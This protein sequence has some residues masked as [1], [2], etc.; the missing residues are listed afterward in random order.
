[1][2]ASSTQTAAT[3]PDLPDREAAIEARRA[4]A[5]SEVAPSLVVAGDSKWQAR[6]SAKTKHLL[7]DATLKALAE[8]GYANTTTLLV[9]EIAAISRGAM[10]HHFRTKGELIEAAIDYVMM[11]RTEQF[12]DDITALSEPERTEEIA[13]VE[14][15][16][17]AM[18]T[19]EYDAYL[20]LANASRTDPELRAVF[21]PA[22]QRANRVWDESLPHLFPEWADHSDAQELARDLISTT[23]KGLLMDFH[24]IEPRARRARL[25]KLVALVTKGLMRGDIPVPQVS[26]FEL[27]RVD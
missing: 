15:V 7:L 5:L 22:S 14:A 8:H 20:E 16:W 6:K 27:S 2:N 12:F 11:R 9:T 24:L 23:M 4:A 1:M 10:L 25:R 19:R 3:A 17:Q 13:G 26:A 21:E 18:K